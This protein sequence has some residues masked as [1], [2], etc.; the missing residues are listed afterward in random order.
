VVKALALFARPE[1]LSAT[2]REV[3]EEIREIKKEIIESRGLIIKTNNL[4]NALGADI[5]A[6]AK[7]QAAHERRT[8]WNSVVAY[9]LLG[10]A[11]LF[12]FRLL[13]DVSLREIEAEKETLSQEVKRLRAAVD[14]EVKRAEKRTQAEAK[15]VQ[16]LELV[17]QKQRAAV[18]ERWASLDKEE[19]SPA[20]RVMFR[21]TVARFQS[22]LSLEAYQSGLELL[23]TGHFTEAVEA[24]EDTLRLDEGAA[25]V[26][27]ARYQLAL[28]ELRLGRH[29]QAKQELERVLEQT[30][31]REVQPAATMALAQVLE[32]QGD[33]DGARAQLRKLMTKWPRS[34]LLP[35]ARQYL[36]ALNLKALRVR[37]AH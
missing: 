36:G 11:C 14:D 13:L 12:G 4:T 16:F 32:E 19:L 29:A 17:R 33:L 28:A 21:D 8:W 15:A 2:M 24:F 34:A 9:A 35:E 5:K 25:H 10:A 27:A 37:E 26:P 1:Y 30:S 7:R 31:D 3:D 23:R 18:L 6:I 22:E 20:E